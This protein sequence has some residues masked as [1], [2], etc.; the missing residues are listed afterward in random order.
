MLISCPN[1]YNTITEL[2][3]IYD[4]RGNKHL[5]GDC[6]C[7]ATGIP[8]IMREGLQIPTKLTKNQLKSEKRRRQ[9][10]LF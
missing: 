9:T 2:F 7:R 10:T 1:C 4:K 6:V 3:Y 8:L 5:R